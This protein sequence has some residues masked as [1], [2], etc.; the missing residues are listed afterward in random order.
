[1]TLSEK[2]HLRDM[3]YIGLNISVHYIIKMSLY[4]SKGGESSSEKIHAEILQL[5]NCS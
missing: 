4:F 3:A 5:C 1:M 2:Y